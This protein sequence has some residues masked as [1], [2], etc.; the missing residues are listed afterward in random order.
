MLSTNDAVIVVAAA[1]SSLMFGLAGLRNQ[2]RGRGSHRPSRAS[3][4]LDALLHERLESLTNKVVCGVGEQVRLSPPLVPAGLAGEWRCCPI[5]CGMN[6]CS[7]SCEGRSGKITLKILKGYER[8]L[9]EGGLP[10]LSVVFQKR[11]LGVAGA[12]VFGRHPNILR[13]VSIS[14]DSPLL[15]YEHADG[16]TLEWQLGHGWEP[17]L[18]DVALLGIQVAAAIKHLHSRGVA[19]GN[20][21]AENTYIVDGIAKLGEP[22][23]KGRRDKS[24]DIAQLGKLI[25]RVATRK[26][27]RSREDAQTALKGISHSGLRGVVKKMIEAKAGEEPTIN[28]V[29]NDLLNAWKELNT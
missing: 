5:G 14:K 15:V 28:E 16:G 22:A 6:G 1:A 27:V 18:R 3:P 24:A 20:I 4:G 12:M 7:Y 10:V 19:H 11:I 21:T 17:T 2:R 8:L 25:L 9:S 13:P 29:I 26:E 23:L